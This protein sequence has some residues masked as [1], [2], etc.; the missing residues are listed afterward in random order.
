M[1]AV[2]LHRVRERRRL[3]LTLLEG[4]NVVSEAIRAG[5]SFVELFALPT[6]ERLAD[7][8]D[9]TLVEPQIM[10]RLAHTET[11]RGPVAVAQIPPWTEPPTDRSVIYLSEVSDP[12][13]VG[14]I[15]RSAAAFGLSV[16]LSEGCADPWSPKAVRAAA[17][18]HFLIPG[19]SRV[20]SPTELRAHRRA[21]LVVDGGVPPGA[22]EEGPW[23]V[24]VGSEAHGLD[25]ALVAECDVQVTIPMPGGME[26][27]NASVAASILA[28]ELSKGDSH[29]H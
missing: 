3:G 9:P 6:D 4:P 18:G 23:V 19:L 17:G 10:R 15:I 16:A 12:G 8:P 22:L 20:G 14:T 13:N 1:E 27:L 25:P 7:W 24:I 5:V 11:P 2:R 26:S 28:Y 21:A 29:P